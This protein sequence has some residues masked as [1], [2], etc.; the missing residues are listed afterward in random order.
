MRVGV[1]G[2]G[3]GAAPIDQEAAAGVVVRV[4]F[5]CIAH[6]IWR[7]HTPSPSAQVAQA[8]QR[9]QQTTR[10]ATRAAQVET[11]LLA[12]CLPH[13]VEATAKAVRQVV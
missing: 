7:R 2:V 12:L 13:T 10:T 11:L 9:K 5:R 3:E 8:A 1:V 4:S 6:P